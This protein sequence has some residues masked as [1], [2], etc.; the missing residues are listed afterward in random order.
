MLSGLV[1]A[2]TLALP[3]VALENGLALT[4]PMGW[5]AW[6][7]FRCNVDC[8]EDPRNCIRSGGGSGGGRALGAPCWGGARRGVCPSPLGLGIPQSLQGGLVL[9]A[10]ARG[11]RL[12]KAEV[13]EGRGGWMSR[14]GQTSGPGQLWHCLLSPG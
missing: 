5:L 3:S 10:P 12:G 9:C 2:L 13:C 8:R 14:S 4:P 11:N 7:R 1:L 6:E